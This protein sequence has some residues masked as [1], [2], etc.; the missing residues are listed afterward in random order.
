MKRYL[1]T[2]LFVGAAVIVGSLYYSQYQQNPWTRDGQ[3][4]A[5]VVQVT[6]RVTG[7]IVQLN[8]QDNSR[9]KQGDTLFVVD[10]MPFKVRLLKALA[11]QEQAE[12]LLAK[13]ENEWLR[14]TGLEKRSPG[15]VPTLSLNNYQTAVDT[16][17]ANLSATQAAVEEARLDLSYTEVKAPANGFVTNLRHH[18][19]AQVMANNPVVALIDEDSFW[20]EG[21]FKETDIS[22]VDVDKTARV[23]LLSEQ[24]IVL[25]GHVESVGYGISKVDGS[26]GYSLL[27]TV[28]PNFQWIR[29][30]QRIPVK[31]KLNHVPDE[32]Q[33]RVG[34]TASVQVHK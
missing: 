22:D 18:V 25:E 17:K 30:A 31:V 24:S 28:N 7:A 32:V 26:T 8:V 3:V 23:T 33:L 9:V 29:L 27:P 16:A 20:I 2:L 14:A 10:P 13:A 5:H 21:F 19:G 34:M 1:V 12:A 15:A 6:P 4:R 11:A